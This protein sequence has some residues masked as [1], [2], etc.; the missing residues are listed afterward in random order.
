MR[1]EPKSDRVLCGPYS[2]QTHM[3]ASSVY[4]QVNFMFIE[5]AYKRAVSLKACLLD[6]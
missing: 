5:S 2:M 1:K 6:L 4:T 3:G